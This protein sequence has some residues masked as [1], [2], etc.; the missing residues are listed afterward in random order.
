MPRH[1]ATRSL[2]RPEL[3]A[4][5]TDPN[6]AIAWALLQ[7]PDGW[8]LGEW[9]ARLMPDGVWRDIEDAAL[10]DQIV[11]AAIRGRGEDPPQ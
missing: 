9:L 7:K 1:N 3:G 10:A 2:V 4:P 8:D 6:E 5:P 11:G